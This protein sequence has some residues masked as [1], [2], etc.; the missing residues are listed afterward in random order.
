MLPSRGRCLRR[1][2]ASPVLL[3][4]I[5]RPP[6]ITALESIRHGTQVR[7]RKKKSGE[8]VEKEADKRL[9]LKRKFEKE[10][11]KKRQKIEKIKAARLSLFKLP[12][13]KPRPDAV[14]FGTA[15]QILRGWGAKSEIFVRC[16]AARWAGETEVVA[17]VRVVPNDHNPRGIKGKVQ[18]PH[19][20]VLR[21]RDGTKKERIAVILEG[22]EGSSEAR[23]AGMIVGGKEYLDKVLT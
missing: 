19:P 3:T 23:K 15:M 11:D 4:P 21:K 2:V 22:E 6:L 8:F 10:L 20:V 12:P 1:I 17:M 14:P 5:H 7:K 16:K 9:R 18:F 13:H